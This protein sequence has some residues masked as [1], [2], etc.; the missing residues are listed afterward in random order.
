MSRVKRGSLC[1]FHC[2]IMANHLLLLISKKSVFLKTKNG[3]NQWSGIILMQRSYS[4]LSCNMMVTVEQQ[5]CVNNKPRATTITRGSKSLSSTT[6]DE[7]ADV[8]EKGILF[9]SLGIVVEFEPL[10]ITQ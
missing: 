6:P 7:K 4:Y 10:L 5:M 9:S 3:G 8:R 1:S 2:L